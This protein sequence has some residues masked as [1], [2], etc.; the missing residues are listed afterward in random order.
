MTATV[1]TAQPRIERLASGTSLERFVR[2]G[3]VRAGVVLAGVVLLCGCG[4]APPV[5]PLTA[6]A[7]V[8][9]RP[10]QNI[11]N[12]ID[13][14]GAIMYDTVHV[15][16]LPPETHP[17]ESVRAVAPAVER[18]VRPPSESGVGPATNPAD[19]AASPPNSPTPPAFPSAVSLTPAGPAPAAVS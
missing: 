5:R 6:E 4:S 3:V 19:L 16:L 15:G 10:P 7:F 11:G 13:K 8:P 12:P 1:G 18:V 9:N 14:P 17:P 2:P